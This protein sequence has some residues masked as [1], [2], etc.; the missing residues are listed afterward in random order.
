MAN[1]I[2][3]WKMRPYYKTKYSYKN[4]Y[5]NWSIKIKFIKKKLH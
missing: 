2:T 3:K 4:K 1:K 5:N